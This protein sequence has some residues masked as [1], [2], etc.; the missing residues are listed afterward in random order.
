MSPRPPFRTLVL[1]MLTA[2]AA[3]ST[4][5]AVAS[6]ADATTAP[7]AA[8]H[9]S[10]VAPTSNPEVTAKRKPSIRVAAPA[11]LVEGTRYAVVVRSTGLRQRL[12]TLQLQR[13]TEDIY[14]NDVWE[15][16]RKTRSARAMTFRTVAGEADLDRYRAVA[17]LKRGRPL[18]SRA[19]VVRVSHW[20]PLV[21]FDSYYETGG[22]NANAYNQFAMNGTSYA[23]SWYTYGGYRSWES[24]YTLGRR[25]TQMR[26]TFG[27]TD[28][29]A[30]GTAGTVRVLAEGTVVAYQ[31]PTLTPGAVTT[32]T[33]P[34]A[35]AYRVSIVGTD[36]TD[37]EAH[38][39]LTSFPAVGDLQVLCHGIA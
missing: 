11:A 14:G 7:T 26:G 20:Y 32:R 36:V 2:A 10:A 16:V 29:S 23:S 30:D 15:T 33:F 4:S 19:A 24:R 6:E 12:R 31:S 8:A 22:V 1:T 34:I 3:V 21:N 39:D 18:T 37:T 28:R 27:V 13:R 25:C 9:S 17:T 38:P 35:N 5:L